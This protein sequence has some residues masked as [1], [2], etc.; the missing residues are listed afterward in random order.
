MYARTTYSELQKIFS[1]QVEKKRKKVNQ[2]TKETKNVDYEKKL[3]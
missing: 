2:K 1:R 3:N